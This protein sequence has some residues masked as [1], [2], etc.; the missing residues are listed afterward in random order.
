MLPPVDIHFNQFSLSFFFVSGVFFLF[1]TNTDNINYTID[2]FVVN[3]IKFSLNLIPMAPIQ[4]KTFFFY[5]K[6]GT[7]LYKAIIVFIYNYIEMKDLN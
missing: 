1:R 4:Q 2:S 6:E 5:T 7:S 3:F